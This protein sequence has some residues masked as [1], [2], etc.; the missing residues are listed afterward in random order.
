M[1]VVE[2][3][4]LAEP[5]VVEHGL[6]PVL[7]VLGLARS[8]W[9]YQPKRQG[10]AERHAALRSPL[11]KI[12]RRHPEYGYR[13]TAA[14]L[15]SRLRR[16]V[17]QKVVR[18]LHQEWDL[19]LIRRAPAPPPSPLRQ[20]IAAAGERV[21]L[22]T[23]LQAIRPF[24]VFYTDFTELVYDGG[25]RSARLMALLDHASK[26]VPGWAVDDRAT[27]RLALAVWRRTKKGLHRLG[28]SWQGVIVHQDQDPVF[29]SGAWVRQLLVI[30][31]ARVSYALQGARDNP[32]MESFYA[33]FKVENRSLF[34]D[35]ESLAELAAVVRDRLRYY[36]RVRRHSS[37]GMQ[38]PLEFVRSL[39][40]HP[41]D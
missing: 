28:R 21:N 6:G 8:T 13:R 41:E 39:P 2:K 17:N 7:S 22:V 24:E 34:L 38:S 25:R 36:N 1:T 37:I 4:T 32:E 29:T 12:A 3:V 5:A 14:E 9:Y 20:I 18:R 11:E 16:P 19:P 31:K 33:R 27:T 35:A 26:L 10:Y 30:D 40:P 15:R 23:G